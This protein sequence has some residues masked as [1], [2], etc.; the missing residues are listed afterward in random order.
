MEKENSLSAD[1][2]RDSLSG[3]QNSSIIVDSCI[4]LLCEGQPIKKEIRGILRNLVDHN[5]TLGI[6]ELSSFEVMKNS[7]V[8]YHSYFTNLVNYINHIPI[9]QNILG[10]ALL[11][12]LAYSKH[13]SNNYK[14][15][16]SVDY[17]IGGTVLYQKDSILL[18]RDEHFLNP[19][20]KTVSHFPI[21][22]LL[23]NKY[24]VL[25]FYFLKP[26]TPLIQNP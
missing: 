18:T 21:F 23:G 26:N 5:N 13:S 3:I 8:K 14:K 20:W 9:N 12:Y 7:N 2:T 22:Y 4:L 10:N 16:S 19:L 15:I 24:E 17:I 11:L 1:I 25:N 6:S